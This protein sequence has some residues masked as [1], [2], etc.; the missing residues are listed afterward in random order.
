MGQYHTPDRERF[1]SD[2]TTPVVPTPPAIPVVP[3]EPAAITPPAEPVK[4]AA[5]WETEA[6]KWKTFSR[7]HEDTSK[8][9]A[10]KAKRFDEFEESQKT[11]IQ[12]HADAATKAQKAAA[13]TAVELARVKAAVKHGLTEDDLDLLGTHGT[14]EEIDA[15]AEK[16]AARIKAADAAKPKPDFGGGDR[17][18]DVGGGAPVDVIDGQIAEATKAGNF[19]TVIALKQQRAALIA[20]GKKS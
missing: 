3:A 10:E 20:E 14:A 13:E 16:L 11:E 19:Q 18:A 5:Y 2:P 15:R 1:M 12:K 9:N 7:K 4:D 8:A 6:E 17:G